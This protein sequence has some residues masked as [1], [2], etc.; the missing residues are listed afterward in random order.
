DLTMLNI[1][2]DSAYAEIRRMEPKLPV[3][4]ASGYDVK[5]V[6][7][8][9]DRTHISSFIQKPF[10]IKDLSN[11]LRDALHTDPPQDV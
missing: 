3:L 4:I 8:R 7:N 6:T 9:F 1:D 5:T 11:H 10:Q 2:G